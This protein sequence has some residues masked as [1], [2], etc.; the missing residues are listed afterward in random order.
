MLKNR[1][2]LAVSLLLVAAF[3]LGACGQ[4]TPTEAP[5]PTEAPPPEPTAVPPT[6]VPLGSPEKPIIMA[7]APSA[8]TRS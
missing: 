3:A 8:N 7:L 5:A 2:F 6:E 1:L 4:A